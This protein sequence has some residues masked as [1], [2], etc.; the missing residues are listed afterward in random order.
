MAAMLG[1]CNDSLLK[2]QQM[3]AM[4]ENEVADVQ[5]KLEKKDEILQ[6]L[7][8]TKEELFVRMQKL[9]QEVDELNN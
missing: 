1:E 9:Q 3:N 2:A 6:E 4:T 8:K 7:L 5:S